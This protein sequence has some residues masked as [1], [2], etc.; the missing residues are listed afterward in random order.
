M[1]WISVKGR[2]PEKNARYL[3]SFE[4]DGKDYLLILSFLVDK[5]QFVE[6]SPEAFSSSPYMICYPSVTHWIALEDIAK[7]E[8]D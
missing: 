1:N 5:Q 3:V 6:L 2:L 8:K 7:P 4:C